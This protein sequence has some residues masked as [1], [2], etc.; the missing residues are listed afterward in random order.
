MFIAYAIA[1]R[2]ALY[3]DWD[4]VSS[5][6][7][8]HLDGAVDR[9]HT[10][11][12]ILKPSPA[13]EGAARLMLVTR[14]VHYKEG[15]LIYADTCVSREGRVIRPGDLVP[16]Y[17]EGNRPSGLVQALLNRLSLPRLPAFRPV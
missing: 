4:Y 2:P 6:G 12:H 11:P 14:L 9:E 15:R 7:F 16:F 1:D 5:A 8:A 3:E 10:M 17:S 13:D